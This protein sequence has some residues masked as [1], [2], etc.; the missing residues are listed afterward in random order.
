MAR[1]VHPLH[2]K[3]ADFLALSNL[4]VQDLAR[5]KVA[6]ELGERSIATANNVIKKARVLSSLGSTHVL[7][8]GTSIVVKLLSRP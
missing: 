5:Q 1:V 3:L 2:T 6:Q 8:L 4:A 7:Y